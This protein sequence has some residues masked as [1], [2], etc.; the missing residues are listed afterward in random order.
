MAVVMLHYHALSGKHWRAFVCP[1]QMLQIELK[2]LQRAQQLAGMDPAAKAASDRQRWAGWL[3][4]YRARL[5]QEADAGASPQ[6]RVDLM[7]ATNP[8]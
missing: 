7:D 8:R 1:P 3:G 2:R 6:M 4:R 5:Q